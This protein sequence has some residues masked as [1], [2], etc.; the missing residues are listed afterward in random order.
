MVS[1]R[2]VKRQVGR[3]IESA[4]R[5][6]REG[7]LPLIV[8]GVVWRPQL[9]FTAQHVGGRNRAGVPFGLMRLV[10]RSVSGRIVFQVVLLVS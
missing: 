7:I 3:R 2:V 6:V 4:L 9:R 5:V 1:G 10:S 8:A